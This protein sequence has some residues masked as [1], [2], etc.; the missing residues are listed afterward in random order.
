[1]A[2]IELFTAHIM[3]R[4]PF[5]FAGNDVVR[6]LY[7][8]GLFAIRVNTLLVFA[9]LILL[10]L[11]LTHINIFTCS[12]SLPLIAIVPIALFL[13]Y[14]T[15]PT[16]LLLVLT[17]FLLLIKMTKREAI[18]KDLSVFAPISLAFILTLSNMLFINHSIMRLLAEI[19]T[20]IASIALFLRFNKQGSL[21]FSS[22]LISIGIPAIILIAPKY[23]IPVMPWTIR[24]V[25]SFSLGF[26]PYLPLEI[27][28]ASLALLLLTF[29]RV[30]QPM[31]KY[32][33]MMLF[34]GDLPHWDIYPLLSLLGY[35]LISYGL[36]IGGVEEVYASPQFL[37][38]HPKVLSNR[39][40]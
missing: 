22:K 2:V 18:M 10:A 36:A 21:S 14:Y 24:Q 23:T 39:R 9:S 17:S 5:L 29:F 15:Y 11:T 16:A 34:L 33:I 37:D 40:S 4:I 1:M 13:P 26:L 7:K 28:A 30:K 25:A 3:G 12:I 8:A 6:V 35:Y 27:Y 20:I 19:S 38:T 32:G 31:I